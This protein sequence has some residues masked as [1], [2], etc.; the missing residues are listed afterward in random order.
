M[1]IFF[2]EIGTRKT[3]NGTWKQKAATPIQPGST[4]G[5]GGGR[6]STF[7]FGG[8]RQTRS[9]SGR[10]AKSEREWEE[11]SSQDT[12][13]N[14]DS[15]A[16]TNA[17]T[18]LNGKRR[19]RRKSKTPEIVELSSDSEI[20]EVQMD[21]EPPV[22]KYS[23]KPTDP[24]LI[25]ACVLRLVFQFQIESELSRIAI[26]S[27]VSIA[28]CQAVFYPKQSEL[29]L[30]WK[31]IT[32]KR[33]RSD[34]Q[35]RFT[36]K[37]LCLRDGTLQSF[38]VYKAP[39]RDDDI[40]A[41]VET[42]A[43]S[44]T[45]D[46]DEGNAEDAAVNHLS[47]FIAMEITPTNQNGLA[48]VRK[49]YIPGHE[50]AKFRY[51][52]LEFRDRDQLS[53]VVD[54]CRPNLLPGVQYEELDRASCANYA[55]S[56]IAN[57]CSEKRLKKRNKFVDGRPLDYTL[58]VYPFAGDAEEMESA[59]RGLTEA[60]RSVEVIEK[61]SNEASDSSND[62]DDQGEGKPRKRAHFVSINVEDYDRLEPAEWLNDSLVDL[63]MQWISRDD[64]TRDSK[65]H[66][67]T[68]HFFSTLASDGPEAVASWTKKKKINI[69]EKRLIFVPINKHMHWSL[70]A[71]VNPGAIVNG[72]D[73]PLTKDDPLSCMIFMDSLRMHDK[74]TVARHVRKWLNSEW[75]RVNS[76][77]LQK[78]SSS[79]VG[80]PFKPDNFKIFSPKGTCTTNL[81]LRSSRLRLSTEM[82]LHR[83]DSSVTE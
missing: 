55:Q 75:Q 70:C 20:E 46:D 49:S 83:R 64:T 44:G 12:F 35:R 57:F 4:F 1:F 11:S 14:T 65:F 45:E 18:T 29:R 68:S 60:S 26:G 33:T 71:I 66:F 52:I 62:D 27:K 36:K 47:S 31:A 51:I 34:D 16:S 78:D 38:A 37:T 7:G 32:T 77:I 58:L 9:Q 13:D 69:F 82:F 28:E 79:I 25:C 3:R 23:A 42:T 15:S 76:G 24:C 48:H 74:R 54:R 8:G 80:E 56:L 2:F 81:I 43:A 39:P 63:W 30:Q 40:S 5:F 19:S 61:K 10:L 59:A 72:L 53:A 67:C 17:S 6:H 50:E 41:P 73:R 21:Y 22:S